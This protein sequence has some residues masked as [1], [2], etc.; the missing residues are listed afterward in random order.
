MC[1]LEPSFPLLQITTAVRVV[2]IKYLQEYEQNV[3]QYYNI[4]VE[5]TSANVSNGRQ[6]PCKAA[7]KP[8]KSIFASWI[9]SQ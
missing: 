8:L 5:S 7:C 6:P 1:I 3:L 2:K 4:H 9:K